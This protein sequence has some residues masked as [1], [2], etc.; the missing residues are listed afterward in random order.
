MLEI[1]GTTANDA[2]MVRKDGSLVLLHGTSSHKLPS[3]LHD[4]LKA[5]VYLT[6]LDEMARYYADV[7]AD[8]DGG[9]PVVLRITIPDH[10]RLAVDHNAWAE[11]V[12]IGD[13]PGEDE[14]WEMLSGMEKVEW[15]DSLKILH[16]VTHNGPITPEWIEVGSLAQAQTLDTRMSLASETA[17]RTLC[18]CSLGQC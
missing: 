17:V 2:G 14:I 10:T 15:M 18:H 5:P 12:I 9:N 11:P 1:Q 13:M 3:I 4:G 8:A 6:D 7:A 16:S